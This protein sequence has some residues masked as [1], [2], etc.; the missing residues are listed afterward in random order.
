MKRLCDVLLIVAL[1]WRVKESRRETLRDRLKLRKQCTKH[2][3]I[4]IPAIMIVLLS[5]P[6]IESVEVSHDKERTMTFNKLTQEEER[7]I[8]LKGTEAPF[9]GKYFD[10]DATGT[11]V[12]R[13][14]DAPL[15]RSKDKFSANCGW[16]SF[17]D[18][19][20]DAVK[21]QPDNNGTRMEIICANCEAHL[22]HVFLNE[23][24]TPKNIRHCINSIS[25]NFI[26]SETFTEFEKVYFAGGC[27]WGVE[28]LLKQQKGVLE[29]ETGYMGGTTESPSYGDICSGSTGH[30]ETVKIIFDPSKTSYEVLAKYF[31]EIHDPTQSDR[32]GPDVGTQY[33]SAI[34]VTGSEQ[35]VVTMELIVSL[36][37]RGVDVVTEVLPA[38]TFWPA[39]EYHQD[40]YQNTGK[41]PYCH[42]YQKRF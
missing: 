7:V 14:C 40:Y 42:F 41:V 31:F 10:H 5:Y 30:T 2:L 4:H 38:G 33:R 13:Q 1:S 8:V 6:I 39:E 28:Y 26:P 32:Q 18:E 36:R 22:G 21:R 37:K 34:F 15:Y 3:F 9:S 25:L 24:L 35:K 12:C 20:P 29:T 17:D 27:F 11:Y 16:P 19:I 23:G